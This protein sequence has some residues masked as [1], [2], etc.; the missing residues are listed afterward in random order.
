MIMPAIVGPFAKSSASGQQDNCVEVAPLSDGGKAVRDSKDQRGP[1]LH[2][3]PGEWAAFVA[4][5]KVG[6]FP[7]A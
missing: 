4:T 7:V 2:F 3:T 1:V 5:V 6:D